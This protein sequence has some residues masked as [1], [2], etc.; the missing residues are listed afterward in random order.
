MTMY[1][2]SPQFLKF[3]DGL[4]DKKYKMPATNAG[5]ATGGMTFKLGAL[6]F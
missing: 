5:F 6:S 2:I 4:V 1:L 3:K